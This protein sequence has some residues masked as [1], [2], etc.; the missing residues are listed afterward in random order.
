MES[1]VLK[2]Q[3][4]YRGYLVRKQNKKIKDGMTFALLNECVDNYIKTVEEEKKLNLLLKNKKIRISNFPS[5]ISENIAKFAIFKKYGIM[6]TWDTD[7]GDLINRRIRCEVKGSID[8][9][10][11][12]SSFGP[13]EEWDYI[14]FV[15]GIENH[16]KRYRV[17]EVKLSNKSEKW[18]NIKVNKTQTYME[19][20]LEKRRPR[21]VFKKIKSQ[22]EKHIAI[23]FDGYLSDLS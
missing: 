7:K 9:S 13:T 2:I 11:G 18:R 16:N 12:P 4:L 14:Y 19:Q 22:I 10:N 20:C 8:L 6:P 21:I 23:I 3:S 5:H 15:D 17:Y 1:A